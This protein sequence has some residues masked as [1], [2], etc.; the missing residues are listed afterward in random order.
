MYNGAM[1]EKENIFKWVEV[2]EDDCSWEY[3]LVNVNGEWKMAKPFF[4]TQDEEK[5]L[6]ILKK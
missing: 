5:I 3:L 1:K 4:G 6:E 2:L